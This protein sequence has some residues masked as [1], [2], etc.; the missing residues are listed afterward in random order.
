MYIK[1]EFSGQKQASLAVGGG[2][3][4]G[5]GFTTVTQTDPHLCPL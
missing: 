1:L 3:W 2:A 5:G 4:G